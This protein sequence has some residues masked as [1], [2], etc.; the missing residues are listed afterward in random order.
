MWD[1]PRP[2]LEPVSPAFADRF[3]TTAPPGKS[4]LLFLYDPW[5][6]N[7]F[8]FFK[9][10]KKFKRRIS[11]LCE[12]CKKFQ[13]QCLLI[14]FYWHTAMP[15][16]L[17]IG[18]GCSCIPRAELSWDRDRLQSLNYL[19]SG[20]L[21][22]CWPLPFNEMV[23]ASRITWQRPKVEVGWLGGVAVLP[24]VSLTFLT[25]RVF[26]P[27]NFLADSTLNPTGQKW[28]TWLSWGWGKK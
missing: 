3:L 11:G 24:H 15:I 10:L 21:R 1:L 27:R 17:R 12:N 19:L 28:V 20:P 8:Y 25:G 9:W 6:E 14:K 4:L 18:C 22:V 26:F 5:A 13:L 23:Q 2:G 16:R 7:I